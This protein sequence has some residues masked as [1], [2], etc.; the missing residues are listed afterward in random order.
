MSNADNGKRFAFAIAREVNLLSKR[1]D[2][3]RADIAKE[4][5]SDTLVTKAQDLARAL[6]TME[7]LD[8]LFTD[9]TGERLTGLLLR[10]ILNEYLEQQS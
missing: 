8:R 3:L 2:V 4:F 7:V 9:A 10:D 1:C 5:D 6:H